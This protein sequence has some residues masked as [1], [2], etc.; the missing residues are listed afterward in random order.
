[1]KACIYGAG[2]VGGH[3][4][5]RLAANTAAEVSLVVRSAAVAPLRER[6]LTL[7]TPTLDDVFLQLTGGHLQAGAEAA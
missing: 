1:M 3:L 6:G 5:T 7:R 4:A 2:A